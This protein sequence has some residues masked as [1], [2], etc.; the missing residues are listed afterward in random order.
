MCHCGEDLQAATIYRGKHHS[1]ILGWFIAAHRKKKKENKAFF[2]IFAFYY[3][4]FSI[5]LNK[6]AV[7][8]KCLCLLLLGRCHLIVCRSWVNEAQYGLLL[9]VFPEHAEPDLQY[10]KIIN[11]ELWKYMVFHC[12]YWGKLHSLLKWTFPPKTIETQL[13][14]TL[15][16]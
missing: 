6:I 3:L 11:I 14:A 15:H 8:H 10:S 12:H 9:H 4:L 16:A 5:F 13:H 2:L 1:D 7:K